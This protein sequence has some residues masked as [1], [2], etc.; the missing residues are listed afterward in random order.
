V[1]DG[2]DNASEHRLSDV[3]EAV[4]RADVILYTVGLFDE[5][6]KDR[7][8]GVLSQLSKASGGVA[9][10]PK[11]VTEATNVLQAVSRDIRNQYTIGYVPKDERQD[12]T[13]RA[14]QVDVVAPHSK[15]WIARTRPGYFAGRVSS[16]LSNDSNSTNHDG[17]QP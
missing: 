15:R 6:D 14:I 9:Y 16:P 3:L 2:G 13:Y 8:P 17:G 11:E 5:Y 10:F 4:K 12:G 7:N 1:S